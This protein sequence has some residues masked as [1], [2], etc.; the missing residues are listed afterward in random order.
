M[1][2]VLAALDLT[3]PPPWAEALTVEVLSG[4][5]AGVPVATATGMEAETL[6]LSTVIW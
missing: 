6:V 1:T 4:Q 5:I 2:V 3:L